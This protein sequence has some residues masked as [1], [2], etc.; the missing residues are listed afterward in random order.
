MRWET[1]GHRRSRRPRT[2]SRPRSAT[3]PYGRGSAWAATA[4]TRRSA[5]RG[6]SRSRA[7][8]TRT[9]STSSTRSRSAAWSTNAVNVRPGGDDFLLAF[10]MRGRGTLAAD[11]PGPRRGRRRRDDR[12]RRARRGSAEFAV[13]YDRS[14]W[15]ATYRVH[16]R[17]AA[18]FRDGPFFLA[19]DAA[20]V[21][22]PV[23]AQGMNTGLQDAHNLAFKLADVLAGRRKD[24]WLDRYEAERRP[25]AHTPGQPPPTGSSRA[26]TSQ[27]PALPP[28]ARVP[29][30]RCWPRSRVRAAA[31]SARAA[32]APV[33]VRLP[34]PHPL[35][36]DA[37]RQARR[38]RP[39]GPGGRPPAPWAGDNFAVLRS[40]AGRSTRT[41]G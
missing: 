25:V 35:L 36:D 9:A 10:P 8:P 13:T 23:G 2:A 6:G 33:P 31:R 39:P 26:I 17:I 37:G 21:H 18:A 38:R 5:R 11:R 40:L 4:P 15:F 20:H 34:D 41:A 12:G 28:A 32:A 24:R 29:P 30:C 1:A 16:H 14:R 19:G 7:S 3:T 27:R 22:S